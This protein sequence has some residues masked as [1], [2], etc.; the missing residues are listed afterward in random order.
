M[1]HIV[2]VQTKV[3]DPAAILA[4]CRRLNLPEPVQGLTSSAAR[5][6]ACSC[7][8]PAGSFLRSSTR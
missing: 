8:C 6:P 1:S 5:P 2:T 3:H 7:S 4:A